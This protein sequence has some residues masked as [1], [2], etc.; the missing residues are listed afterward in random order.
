MAENYLIDP[1]YSVPGVKVLPVN[2][3]NVGTIEF[4]TQHHFPVQYPKNFYERV[5][6]ASE[7]RHLTYLAYLNDVAIG[8]IVCFLE[9]KTSET[10]GTWEQGILVGTRAPTSI[11]SGDRTPGN[12]Y[13]PHT[14][15]FPSR[16]GNQRGGSG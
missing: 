14:K 15:R 7:Y 13:Y 5:S 8:C 3:Y 6:T 11:S 16:V 9:P 12:P 4:L 2:S 10:P 1:S